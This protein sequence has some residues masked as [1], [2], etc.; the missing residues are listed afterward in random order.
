[1][2]QLAAGLWHWTARHPE[3][4]PGVFGA[5]VGSYALRAGDELLLVDPLVLDDAREAVDDLAAGARAVR[6]LITIGYHA[7]SAEA[8]ARR[9]GCRVYGP[10]KVASRLGDRSLLEVLEPGG[11]GP[12]GVRA[13]A[14]GRPVRGERPL[15]LPSHRAIAFGDAVVT[16]P[17]GDLR[18]WAQERPDERRVRC[19]T[20]FNPTLEPLVAL[21]PQ[22]I[23]TTH[24]APV[25]AGG[26]A[27]LRGALAGEPWYSRG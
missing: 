16:T 25:L 5:E 4:H 22:R 21:K 19:T 11:D 13:F 6:V 27:A 7:R 8:L 1:M 15:W 23:L 14:I 12:A 17:R 24:G 9:Y 10:P 3:W 20:S 2:R 26:S 18:V